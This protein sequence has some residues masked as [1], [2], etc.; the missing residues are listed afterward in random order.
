MGNFKYLWL[1]PQ[2]SDCGFLPRSR[3]FSCSMV[4]LSAAPNALSGLSGSVGLPVSCG[5]SSR[6][7]VQRQS[8]LA[9]LLTICLTMA[10]RLLIFL[11]PP[12]SS[13][14]EQAR[15][16]LGTAW[17]AFRIAGPALL[18]AGVTRRFAVAHGVITLL[19]SQHWRPPPRARG[20]Q[21]CGRSPRCGRSAPASGG[22]SY[23]L[24]CLA[25]ERH[26]LHR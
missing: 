18:E 6:S 9:A 8:P 26:A 22:Q 15:Q 17:P 14:D 2:S 5:S 4:F 20:H 10:W 7:L 25:G 21:S 3:A 13:V 1:G 16:V 19:V 12:F 11:R 24:R 23:R